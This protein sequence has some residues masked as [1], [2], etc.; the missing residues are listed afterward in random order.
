MQEN[1]AAYAVMTR[2]NYATPEMAGTAINYLYKVFADADKVKVFED[3]GIN[4]YEEQNGEMVS[5]DIANIMQDVSLVV[6]ESEVAAKAWSEL[7]P[8]VR[9]SRA[10]IAIGDNIEL[11]QQYVGEI[12]SADGAMMSAFDKQTSG[13]IAKSTVFTNILTSLKMEFGKAWIPILKPVKWFI[14]EIATTFLKLPAPIKSTAMVLFTLGAGVT[15]LAGTALVAAGTL[16]IFTTSITAAGG[17]SAIATGGIAM[18]TGGVSVLTGG[19]AVLGSAIWVAMAP[20]LPFIAAFGALVLIAQDFWVG[21]NGGQS[22]IFEFADSLIETFGVVE[23]I[24]Y[25]FGVLNDV[26][27]MSGGELIMSFLNGMLGIMNGS[28]AKDL[29]THIFNDVREYLP[30]SD[31]KTGPLSDL[32]ASGGRFVDTFLSGAQA[33]SGN[34]GAILDGIFTAMHPLG[35]M[36]SMTSQQGASATPSIIVEVNVTGNTIAGGADSLGELAGLTAA[37]V[38]RALEQIINKNAAKV[39]WR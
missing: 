33:A 37:A 17:A 32:T 23:N 7:F 11:Y 1:L 35:A 22:L 21:L 25:L 6:S 9:A 8:D 13:Y 12:E 4:I 34:R 2:L 30:F 16:A 27:N 26:A 5:R 3:M 14:G 24:E 29:L 18:L 38:E 39:G 15:L 20:L 19:V 10:A 31:A 36:A 28:V